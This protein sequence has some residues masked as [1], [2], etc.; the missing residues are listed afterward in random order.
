MKRHSVINKESFRRFRQKSLKC[1]LAILRRKLLK[2][3][4]YIMLA[5]KIEPCFMK[6][7]YAF[8]LLIY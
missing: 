2:D 6:V 7:R 8:C 3:V 4:R 1:V 5:K